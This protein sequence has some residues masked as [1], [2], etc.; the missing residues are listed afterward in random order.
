VSRDQL[1]VPS[2]LA[3]AHEVLRHRQPAKD[4]DPRVWV[5]FHRQSAKVYGQTADVDKRHR[6]EA[7]QCAG[8]EIRKARTIEHALDPELDGDE[9]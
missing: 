2:S 3:E 8:M 5:E 4:A 6:H 1:A 7:L 9:S